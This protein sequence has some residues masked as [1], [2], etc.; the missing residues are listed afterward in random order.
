M[1]SLSSPRSATETRGQD[2]GENPISQ[3]TANPNA[4]CWGTLNPCPQ[5][6]GENS[7]FSQLGVSGA[8]TVAA[9]FFSASSLAKPVSGGIR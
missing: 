1:T 9:A 4:M 7:T 6:P 5:S 8:A 2:L 3:S